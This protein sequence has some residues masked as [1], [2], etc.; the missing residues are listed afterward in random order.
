M[1]QPTYV[2]PA[3]PPKHLNHLRLPCV[4]I[5]TVLLLCASPARASQAEVVELYRDCQIVDITIIIDPGVLTPDQS[6]EVKARAAAAVNDDP[7]A[8]MPRVVRLLKERGVGEVTINRQGFGGCEPDTSG[9][10]VEAVGTYCGANLT[11]AEVRVDR[12]TL[13]SRDDPDMT[14]EEFLREAATRLREQ[15]IYDRPVVSIENAPNCEPADQSD[16]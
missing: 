8:A 13:M 5:L 2:E 1:H 9:K 14:F 15:G 3:M 16:G 12:Q 10:F 11:F 6:A 7:R 4:F